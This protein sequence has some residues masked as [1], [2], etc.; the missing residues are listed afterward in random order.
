MK[1]LYWKSGELKLDRPR[2]MGV[3]NMT[4]DSFSDGGAYFSLDRAV[5]RAWEMAN[6]GADLID[7]GAESTRPGSEGISE[8]EERRRLWP[9]LENLRAKSFSLPISLDCTKPALVA[10]AL[11]EGLVQIVNDVEGLRNPSMRDV[12]LERKA[13]IIVMHMFGTPR[14]MQNDFRYDD[15]VKDL[16][17]FFRVRM[18]ETGLKENIVIDPG[19]GFGKSIEQNLSLLHRLAEFKVLNAP[20]LIGASRK[21]FIEKILDLDMDE[22]LEGSLAAAAVAVYNGAAMVRVHDVQPTV[23]IVRLVEAILRSN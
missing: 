13:P 9:L 6:E 8:E 23:R 2:V 15:V 14:T 4:P 18:E 21:S 5:A 22:R 7:I 3:L 16:I 11:D 20:I 10:D 17:S 1:R 12:I 19:I